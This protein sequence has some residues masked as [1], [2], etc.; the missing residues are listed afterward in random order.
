M[1]DRTVL[2]IPLVYLIA[3]AIGSLVPRKGIRPIKEQFTATLYIK[4]ALDAG[5]LRDTFFLAERDIAI[6]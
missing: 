1:G 6:R 5:F 2:A 3:A 4:A